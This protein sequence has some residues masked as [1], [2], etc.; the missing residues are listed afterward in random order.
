MAGTLTIQDRWTVVNGSYEPGTVTTNDSITLT[1]QG[2]AG[3]IQII[4]TTEEVV[5][6]GDLSTR[7]WLRM[8]NLDSTNF[9]TWG[10]ESGGAMVAC[11]RL[12]AGESAKLRTGPAVIIRAQADTANCKLW[13]E[14]LE[15]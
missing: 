13:Y 11:G 9:I 3:G 2:A 15:D 6:A 1:G 5:S 4:G 7:G 8:V 10:P 12:E 14:W